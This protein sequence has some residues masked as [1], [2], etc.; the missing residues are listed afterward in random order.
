MANKDQKR[1]KDNPQDKTQSKNKNSQSPFGNAPK[2]F[3]KFSNPNKFSGGAPKSST[4]F[5]RRTG[6]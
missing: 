4:T 1:Q 6:K 3:E 5:H 2:P